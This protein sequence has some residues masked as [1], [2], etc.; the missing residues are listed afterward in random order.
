MLSTCSSV[1]TGS[2][3]RRDRYG[4]TNQSLQWAFEIRPSVGGDG[5]GEKGRL[6]THFTHFALLL[7]HWLQRL[8]LSLFPSWKT[9]LILPLWNCPC[10]GDCR[11]LRC[12]SGSTPSLAWVSVHAYMCVHW[13]QLEMILMGK[14]VET[15]QT[16]GVE[17]LWWFF[18]HQ[19]CLSTSIYNGNV[20]LVCFL[21]QV[22]CPIATAAFEVAYCHHQL[23]RRRY[24]SSLSNK[25]PCYI[26]VTRG[27]IKE[28]V[29]PAS[30][31]NLHLCW[32]DFRPK[33]TCLAALGQSVSEYERKRTV[34]MNCW[35]ARRGSQAG[36]AE[37]SWPLLTGQVDN[38]FID[39]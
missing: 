32:W 31:Q 22:L 16:G 1:P 29:S 24:C 36:R 18:M 30:C 20:M 27:D 12:C 15:Y 23:H 21:L 14:G 39:R 6:W 2:K 3:V 37:W 35:T 10:T 4:L 17:V 25:V 19:L 13:K 28:D 33:S 26:H 9:W 8:G 38:Y 34:D 11:R 5:G 7:H